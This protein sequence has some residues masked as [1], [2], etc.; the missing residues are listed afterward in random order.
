MQKMVSGLCDELWRAAELAVVSSF[1]RLTQKTVSGMCDE[2]QRSVELAEVSSFEFLRSKQEKFGC[3]AVLN[4]YQA[5]TEHCATRETRHMA[6]LPDNRGR[7]RASLL[8]LYP[9]LTRNGEQARKHTPAFVMMLAQSLP[10][11]L[12]LFDLLSA[13][14][15]HNSSQKV[16]TAL[17]MMVMASRFSL[18]SNQVCEKFS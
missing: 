16:E 1:S 15:Q 9:M 8:M 10:E 6:R 4:V 12:H 13:S 14:D 2:L 17:H 7:K 11:D 3:A 18:S 5:G